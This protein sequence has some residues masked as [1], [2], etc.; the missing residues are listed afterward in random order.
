MTLCYQE[1][2]IHADSLVLM[3]PEAEI[4][5][6]CKQKNILK[7][8]VCAYKLSGSKQFSCHRKVSCMI[9]EISCEIQ[10]SHS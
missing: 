6:A 1:N 7:K 2:I 8:R 5:A 4:C 10:D 9:T 3:F